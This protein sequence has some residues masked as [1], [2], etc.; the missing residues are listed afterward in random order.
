LQL[1]YSVTIQFNYYVDNAP[2]DS[3]ALSTLLLSHQLSVSNTVCWFSSI[4]F[5][6]KDF[7]NFV[8]C[9]TLSTREQKYWTVSPQVHVRI[10]LYRIK[11]S[12]WSL[13]CH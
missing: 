5:S 11:R 3:G 2:D 1:Q 6:Q 8:Y 10:L 7:L 9:G 13:D 4:T 12:F